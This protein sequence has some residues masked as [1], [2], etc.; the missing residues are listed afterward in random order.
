MKGS[1][2][3]TLQ[4]IHLVLLFVPYIVTHWHLYI[5]AEQ[6][7]SLGAKNRMLADILPCLCLRKYVNSASKSK[8]PPQGDQGM[9]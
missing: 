2:Q 4:T 3:F 9:S 1:L 8:L 7:T 5:E 6:K